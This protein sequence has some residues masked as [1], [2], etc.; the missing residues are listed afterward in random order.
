MHTSFTK[1]SGRLPCVVILGCAR[2][3]TSILG[4][5]FEKFPGYHYQFEPHLDSNNYSATI[6]TF[7]SPF[8]LKRPKLSHDATSDRTHGL[9]FHWPTLF[10]ALPTYHIVIWI[11]RHPLDTVC[12]L[13]P[14]ILNEWNHSPRPPNWQELRKLPWEEQCA[15]HWAYINGRGFNAVNHV[16]KI[17]RYENMVG[18]SIGTARQLCD[19]IGWTD[20]IPKEII[21]WAKSIGNKKGETQYEAKLQTRWSENNHLRRV[22]RHRENL[23]DEQRARIRSILQTEASLFNYDLA[24]APSVPN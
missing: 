21:E 2:S 20:T 22:G 3:G 23:N 15:T 7:P 14:G 12:S 11:V 8:A 18:D 13:R 6:S 4:E 24:D 5:F 17:I 16:A 9:A 1:N 19:W 10:A